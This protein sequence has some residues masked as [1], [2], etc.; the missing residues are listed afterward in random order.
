MFDGA[1][2]PLYR[3]LG[4]AASDHRPDLI[5]VRTGRRRF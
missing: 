4:A 5:F 3:L 2:S 1:E